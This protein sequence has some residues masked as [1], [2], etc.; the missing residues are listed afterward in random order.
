MSLSVTLCLIVQGP[1]G[2][3]VAP[4]GSSVVL[5]CSVDQL[6]SVEG[7]EVEWRRTDSDT[8]VHLFQDGETQTGVQ[9]ED[10]Q[11]RAHFFTEEIQRGNFSLRLDN[12]RSKDEGQYTCTVHIQQETGETVVEIKVDNV[13]HLRVS[14]SSR[15][16]SASVGE[17]VTLS[18]SVDSHITPEDLEVSWMK[19]DEDD[20]IVV[21]L[22]QNNEALPEASDERYRDRVEFFTDEIPKGNFSLRL[23]SVRTEDKG[24]YMCEVFAGGLS[25]N[26][27]AVLERLDLVFRLQKSL[28]FCPNIL[29]FLAFVLWG[30]SEV[31]VTEVGKKSGRIIDIFNV[32]AEMTFQIL[33]TLQF[34]LLFYTFG[35]AGAE[36]IMIILPVLLMMTNDRW[37]E[38]CYDRLNCS[39]LVIRT[40]MLIFIIVTNIVMIGVFIFTLDNKTDFHRYAAVYVFGSVVVVL[41][42]SA[43]LTTE[44]ILK[45]GE[46]GRDIFNTWALTT[47]EAELRLLVEDCAYADSEEMVRDRIVFGIHSPRVR[48]KLLSVG[49]ELTLDKAMDIARSHEVAQAQLKTFANSACN[50][51][52]QVVHD[53]T[54]Q[55]ESQKRAKKAEMKASHRNSNDVAERGRNCGYCG[56]QAHGAS[57]KCPAK[58]KQCGKCGKRNHF[59]KVCR[60]AYKRNVY[61]V[62]EEVSHY[63]EDP[64]EFFVDSVSQKPGDTEQAF[65]D[66]LLGVEETEVSFKLDTGAQ[67]NVIPLHTFDR[68]KAQCK[69]LPTK[70]SLTGYGGQVLTVEGTCALPC[71]YKDRETLMN[72]YIVNTQAPPVLGLKACLDLDLIKLVLSVNALKEDK[73]IMEEYPD[74]SDGIGL[75]PGECTIHLK[76]DATPV[77]YPPRRVPLALRGRLK[78]ELQNMEKQGVIARVTEPT[79]WVNALVVVEKPRTRKLRICLD[80]R[81]L[82]KAIKL[83]P[84]PTIEDITPKLMGAK[85]FSVLDACSGYWAIKLTEESSKLTTFNTTF[86]RYRFRR[87]PF[88]IISAQDEF[89]RKI[90]ET[91]EG[92]NGVVAIVDDILVY[93]RTKKEHDD[94]L[95]AMLQRSREKGVKLNP[96]KSIVSATEVRYFGHCL[97]AEGIKPDPEKVSAIKNMEPPKSKAE[98]ETVLGMI[99][100]LSKFVPCLSDINSPLRLLLKQS[101]EFIWDSQHDDAFQKMKELITKEPGPILACYDPQKELHLQVDASKYGL[102]AVLLQDGKPLSYASRSLTECE[103]SYAQIEKELYAVLFGCKRFHQYVYGREV[104]VESDHKPLESVIKKPLAAAP[105][106]LQRMILQLQKYDITIT[107]RPGKEIPVADTLS[108]KSIESEH[109]N[110]SEGMDMQVHMVYKSLPVSD[111]KL[112]QIRAETES[113]NQLIQLRQVILDGWPGEKKK[114]PTDISDFWN[115]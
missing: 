57:E 43:A 73:S 104:I 52:D 109:D 55:R 31:L 56:H 37:F 115:F 23:K 16:I 10:Y 41:L 61:A 76:P 79:D 85:Y 86:G 80:P 5:P 82:N 8:L 53:V 65:A 112:Q 35:S 44:L 110:L 51:R 70:H 38:R 12:L 49:S 18:C 63:E 93:G 29:M 6:L 50:P 101:S 13:E 20:E 21:L 25:A 91:Y 111:I 33:P 54:A 113:D 105:P 74:V 22:Y 103:V 30:V 114:C 46:K 71:R 11:D 59:A 92:L 4:L 97:S 95:Y 64:P 34:I 7:L 60:S 81:D 106:R 62:S 77:V 28:V 48:E 108:R 94:N 1:S 17:D 69:L 26:T 9:Q 47:D 88:G 32:V 87:L 15:S 96:E 24:V 99:N 107:H 42:N 66:I 39:E 102:G 58:G 40:T 14:G 75:F 100:Y 3:L 45:T 2:P 19:T 83:Y 84:L 36:I 78:E 98:L 89:Q 67:V 68:L 90:D 72:F 27:T